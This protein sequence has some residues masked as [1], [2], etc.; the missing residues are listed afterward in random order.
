M[1]S[2]DVGKGEPLTSWLIA[3][4]RLPILRKL[5]ENQSVLGLTTGVI[6]CRSPWRIVEAKEFPDQSKKED[7]HEKARYVCV[8]GDYWLV[9]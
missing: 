5:K 4:G 9:F 6:G 2:E 3:A 8:R 7:L 1:D